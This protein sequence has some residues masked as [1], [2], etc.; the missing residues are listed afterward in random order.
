MDL[1]NDDEPIGDRFDGIEVPAWIDDDISPY[2]VAAIVQGGCASGAY[3]PAVTYNAANDTMHSWGDDVL[4]YISD[5]LGELP[6]PDPATS[7]SG[8]ACHFLSIAV[9]LWASE[10]HSILESLDEPEEEDAA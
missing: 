8:M 1:W 3:M 6:M 5:R 7:W 10:A 9:E 4:D 2:D